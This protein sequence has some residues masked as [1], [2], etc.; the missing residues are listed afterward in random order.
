ML[1]LGLDPDKGYALVRHGIIGEDGKYHEKQTQIIGAG[2]VKGIVQLKKII[3]DCKV[4]AAD[5]GFLK[6]FKGGFLV[7]IERPTNLKTFPRPG[8]SHAAQMKIAQNCGQN[9]RKATELGEYCEELGLRYEF[10]APSRK[11][12]GKIPWKQFNRLTGYTG[13]TSEHSRDAIMIA[14]RK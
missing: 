14:L 10:V 5:D 13:R 6:G 11:K 7:R 9:Y 1:V 12:W 8:L 4:Y 3:A 2:T